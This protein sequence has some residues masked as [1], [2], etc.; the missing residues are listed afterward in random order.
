MASPLHCTACGAEISADRRNGLCIR[1]L[2]ALGLSTSVEAPP[3]AERPAPEAE[4]RIPK[5]QTP[6]AFG[7]YELLEEIARGGMGVVYKARQVSLDRIVAVKLLLAGTLSGPEYVKRF[8][9]EASAA[10]RLQ[11]PNIVAI[12]E[13]G[14]HQGQH[15]LVMDYVEGQSL[16]KTISDFGFR[17][18]DF[19]RIA[20]WVKTAAEAVHHAH[21]HGILH[22]DLKPSNVLI[23]ADG[24]PRVT[25][26]G[27]AKRLA[28]SAMEGRKSEMEATLSGQLVGSPSY[29]PP[30]Q[31]AARWGKV[32]RRSDVYGLGALLYHLLTGR[33]PFQA[34]TIAETL[35]QVFTAEPVAPR[36]L[37]PSLPRDLETICLKCLEKE[38]AKRYPTAQALADELDRFL[39]GRPVRARPVGPAGRLGRWCRRNPRQAGLTAGLMLVFALGLAGVLWQWRLAEAARREAVVNLRDSY[40]AQ[41]RANRWSGRA[42]QRFDSLGALARAARIR[43]SRELRDEAVACLMLPDAEVF[44][45][46]SLP[47]GYDFDFDARLERYARA[48]PEGGIVIRRVSDGAEL[49]RLPGL[50]KPETVRLRFSPDGRFLAEKWSGTRTNRFRVWDLNRRTVI[51]EP[52]IAVSQFAVQFTPDSQRLAAAEADGRVHVYALAE[53]GELTTIS[54]LPRPTELVFDPQI[55]RLAVCGEEDP[56]VRVLDLA[57]GEVTQTL[58]HPVGIFGLAWNRDGRR[59]ACAAGNLCVYLWNSLTGER[60]AA[61]E[62]HASAVTGVLFNHRSDLLVSA[63]WDGRTCFWDPVLHRPLFSL[64][65]R[66][67]SAFSPDDTRLGFVTRSPTITSAGLWRVT[68][69]PECRRLGRWAPVIPGN[70]AAFSADQRLLAVA[71]REGVRVWDAATGRPLASILAGDCRTPLF[72]PGGG[73]ITSGIPGVQRWPLAWDAAAETLVVGTPEALW[74]GVAEHAALTPDGERLVVVGLQAPDADALVIPLREGTAPVRLTG[75]PRSTW[76]SVSPD[77]RQF[78]TGNWQGRDVCVRE[79]DTGRVIAGLPAG[80]SVSVAFSPDGQ[81]LLTGSAGEYRFWNTRSWQPERSLPRAPASDY[82]GAMAFAPD[83]GIVAVVHQRDTEMKL[84]A[85][86]DGRELVTLPAGFPLAFSPDS[87]LLVTLAEDQRTVLLWDLVLIRQQLAAINLDWP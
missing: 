22:R 28:A 17:I 14:V 54:A 21:E 39:N 33:P 29:L 36:A 58:R 69:A 45:Q 40:L 7:D 64:P 83:G 47:P 68:A 10:A 78:A 50:G 49:L 79:L 32:S 62:R 37:N 31:A 44:H 57:S 74:S 13:V 53:G 85:V 76:V 8:R 66:F 20:R 19:P 86:V 46:W 43:P 24:Q 51:L 5:P 72:L 35:E 6:G 52:P 11:H 59:L 67:T 34:A 87:R 77:G 84:L 55:T 41:A 38:P 15:Y 3:P 1:C 30:E 82:V 71:T 73:L 12:H 25:D 26:F 48:E 4:S 23:A 70:T 61:L 18:S 75:H 56:V 16:A 2:L 80:R 42:G 60:Q 81:W 27:L 65:G 9:L 63:G